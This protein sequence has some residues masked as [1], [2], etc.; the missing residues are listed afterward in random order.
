MKILKNIV[1]IFLFITC[2]ENYG[3]K[4]I[5]QS[6]IETKLFL[7]HFFNNDSLTYYIKE[8]GQAENCEKI[9]SNS[10]I[11]KKEANYI[12]SLLLN[13]KKST[14]KISPLPNVKIIID[15]EFYKIDKD[16]I[17]RNKKNR[18]LII[19]KPIFFQKGK[20]CIFYY[21]D[22]FSGLGGSDELAL[23]EKSS[24]IWIK[25]EE[26]CTSIN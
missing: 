2:F 4:K 22:F 12:N 18:V 24:G 8:V 21:K 1:I 17:L 20:F 7:K 19:S 15:K 26:F 25:K 16:S 5:T 11:S 13:K 3:Q 14:Y 23:Y 9:Y 10:F 6:E